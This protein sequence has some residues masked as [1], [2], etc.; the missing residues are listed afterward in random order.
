MAPC[1]FY[2]FGY[3]K[4]RLERMFLYAPAAI[5]AEVAEILRDIST[6]E[7]VTVFDEWKDNLKRCITAEGEYL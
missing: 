3:L 5:V 1:D 6:I 4:I 7:W 2:L